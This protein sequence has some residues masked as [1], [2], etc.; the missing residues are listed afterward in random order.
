MQ[1]LVRALLALATAFPVTVAVAQQQTTNSTSPN[2]RDVAGCVDSE[3]IARVAGSTLTNCQQSQSGNVSIAVGKDSAGNPALQSIQGTERAWTY[4]APVGVA[5]QQLY[6]MASDIAKEAGFTILFEQPPTFFTASKSGAWLEIRLGPNSYTQRIIISAAPQPETSNA[7]PATPAGE[8]ARQGH[9]A[10]YNIQFD[11]STG[12][13]ATGSDAGLDEIA[14]ILQG[15]PAEKVEIQVYSAHSGDA[16]SDLAL[17]NKEA[18]AIVDWLVR[19]GID[20]ARLSPHGMGSANP[21]H[22]ANTPPTRQEQNRVDIV[23]MQ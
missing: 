21:V 19:R 12:A 23:K 13:L 22:A 5:N 11:P 18:Q 20:R 16:A 8:F 2:P 7:P 10:I 9:A 6:S 17:T 1:R 3:L 14:S 4:S 15:N